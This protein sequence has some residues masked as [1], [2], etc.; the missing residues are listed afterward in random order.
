MVVRFKLRTMDTRKWLLLFFLLFVMT[1]VALYWSGARPHVDLSNLQFASKGEMVA[2]GEYIA[3]LAGCVSCHTDSSHGGAAFAGGEPLEIEGMGSFV[4]GNI[5]PDPEAGIGSWSAEEFVVALS[6]G[7]SPEGK[8]Y[9][10]VFPYTSFSKMRTE[11]LVAIY[12]YLQT[13]PPIP[14][15]SAAQ[16][17]KWYLPRGGIRFWKKLYFEPSNLQPDPLQPAQ[18]NRG[19]YLVNAV[20]HCSE[21]HT[22]RNKLGAL[23]KGAEFSGNPVLP[24]G[25]EA[26]NISSS[27]TSGIGYWSTAD[28]KRFL[29]LGVRPDG[30]RVTGMMARVVQGS[31][32][33]LSASDLDAVAAYLQSIPALD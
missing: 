23:V 18:W 7:L 20:L 1:L 19:S 17:P 25:E 8:H 10:P 5:T 14:Q 24:G 30:E 21:C 2:R 4:G 11:D 29:R 31:T 12:E 16:R 13:V 26:P 27:K 32:A 33:N 22:P 3:E 6:Y 9:Y 15:A 28:I